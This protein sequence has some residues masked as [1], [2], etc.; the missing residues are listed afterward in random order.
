MCDTCHSSTN[1][2]DKIFNCSHVYC[3]ECLYYN[4]FS[5][6]S[7]IYKVEEGMRLRFPCPQC[8]AESFS[9]LDDFLIE[10]NSLV[11]LEKN[12][13]CQA[14]EENKLN[15]YCVNC[16]IY[17]CNDCIDKKHNVIAKFK[18]H[19]LSKELSLLSTLNKCN[20]MKNRVVT[21]F[22]NTCDIAV[23]ERCTLV[24]HIDHSLKHISQEYKG[25]TNFSDENKNLIRVKQEFN[26][27]DEMS[28]IDTIIGLSD[29]YSGP[30][31]EL[32]KNFHAYFGNKIKEFSEKLSKLC[33]TSNLKICMYVEIFKRY[34]HRLAMLQ[35][36]IVKL[37]EKEKHPY[38]NIKKLCDSEKLKIINKTLRFH[39]G[40]STSLQNDVSTIEK[41]SNFENK[42]KVSIIE[43]KI[44]FKG[45]LIKVFKEQS[46]IL[47]SSNL[48]QEVL[49]HML[50]TFRCSTGQCFVAY[51]NNKDYTIEL[52][53]ITKISKFK[54]FS[55]NVYEKNDISK[56]K[57]QARKQT[58][59]LITKI[60]DKPN[61]KIIEN[62]QSNSPFKDLSKIS[63]DEIKKQKIKKEKEVKRK[64]TVFSS[65]A[66]TETLLYNEP[67]YSLSAH[68]GTIYGI[69]HYKVEK[70]DMLITYSEDCT[71][72]LWSCD[73]LREISSIDHEKPVR[74]ANIISHDNFK[75]IIV[76]SF[77]K[78]YP[79]AIYT[80]TGSF[81]NEFKIT[82][83]T[84]YVEGYCDDNKC[85]VFVSTYQPY[86]LLVFNFDNSE[87]MYNIQTTTYVNSIIVTPFETL[88]LSYLDRSGEFR[89][90]CLDTGKLLLTRK[91]FGS[92]HI[93]KLNERFYLLCGIGYGFSIFD[94]ND[95]SIYTEYTDVHNGIVKGAC[96]FQHHYY[97]DII[98]TIGNDNKINIL[99]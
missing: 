42:R 43:G 16:K 82:G 62:N 75:Y 20:C 27:D 52:I 58:S 91:D 60:S 90:Y 50:C 64:K 79:V 74:C 25:L 26:I 97:G 78:D 53:N 15:V 48:Y 95:L 24:F 13:N 2:K 81:V 28:K 84:Y 76:G 94:I 11:Q 98:V 54:K 88:I 23:C 83:Y 80:L 21:F 47:I 93:T 61:T 59:N 51:F 67:F 8:K 4:C 22:C 65:I 14:C 6:I 46:T 7:K 68:K 40:L 18:S 3:N 9:N 72:K 77:I 49:P 30:N 31:V 37:I 19:I 33:Q 85:L 44:T 63:K 55:G 92:Y 1:L 66:L 57:E 86:S 10:E 38:L 36:N 35:K 73:F 39:K 70:E 12:K 69:R 96:R 71:V 99:K 34:L 32:F 41:L 89:Q 56:D 45:D 87:L 5:Y 29:K 17:Y